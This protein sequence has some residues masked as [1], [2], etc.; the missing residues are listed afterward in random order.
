M[1]EYSDSVSCNIQ[2]ALIVSVENLS[3]I[4]NIINFEMYLLPKFTL[5][6]SILL[7]LKTH[8]TPVFQYYSQHSF[9]NLGSVHFYIPST[10]YLYHPVICLVI[11]LPSNM[12]RNCKTLLMVQKPDTHNIQALMC[13]T[14]LPPVTLV[15]CLP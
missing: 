14:E 9:E 11:F 2:F 15:T 6:I 4:I 13:R 12:E 7:T 1:I 10:L 5:H 8:S 3:P